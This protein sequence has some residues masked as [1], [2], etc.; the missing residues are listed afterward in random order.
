MNVDLRAREQ[1]T[2]LQLAQHRRR[3]LKQARCLARDP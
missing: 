2:V 1:F 3:E